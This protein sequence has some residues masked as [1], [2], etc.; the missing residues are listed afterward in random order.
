MIANG[1]P[2]SQPD[3]RGG[4]RVGFDEERKVIL[5]LVKEGRLEP[6]EAVTLLDALERAGREAEVKPGAEAGAGSRAEATLRTGAGSG[7][8][9]DPRERADRAEYGDGEGDQETDGDAKRGD[10]KGIPTR[11]EIDQWLDRLG[12]RLH[13]LGDKLE[14]VREKVGEAISQARNRMTEVGE[15]GKEEWEKTW[16]TIQRTVGQVIADIPHMMGGRGGASFMRMDWDPLKG[17]PG[18]RMER[19][20]TLPDFEEGAEVE[21][22]TRNGTIVVEGTDGP[23]TLSMKLRLRVDGE[24]A[25]EA[26]AAQL[27]TAK[28]DEK[29][30]RLETHEERGERVDLH[31]TLPR[32]RNLALTAE[33]INGRLTVRDM[34][35]D[36]LSLRTFNGHV[37]LI[38]V[39]GSTGEVETGNGEVRVEGFVGETLNCSTSN[40][41]IWARAAVRRGRLRTLNGGI[42]LEPAQ[43]PVDVSP[44]EERAYDVETTNGRIRVA[45]PVSERVG[46]RLDVETLE[47]RIVLAL[48]DIQSVVHESP[49]RGGLRAQSFGFDERPERVD[50]RVRS[51]NGSIGIEAGGL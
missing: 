42:D 9:G 2:E 23:P 20:L 47:G 11:E 18:H 39:R 34:A 29:G 48:E 24:S 43:F 16:E 12:E 37:E 49:G 19:S 1:E 15:G 14:G 22:L 46:Y 4:G 7:E 50:L 33:T 30:W 26:R 32:Q 10:G 21:I 45:V 5:R 8:H 51:R 44:V 41:S 6:D 17:R 36:G 25:A 27:I 38:R 28:G 3:R 31:L 35:L 13:G 40:G